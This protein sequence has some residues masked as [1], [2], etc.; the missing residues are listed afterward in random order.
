MRPSGARFAV[1]ENANEP[2]ALRLWSAV[3]SRNNR[4]LGALLRFSAWLGE[5]SDD[6]QVAMLVGAYLAVQLAMIIVARLG[7]PGLQPILLWSWVGFCIFSW[8]APTLVENLLARD[9]IGAQRD[10]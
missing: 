7:V 5:R 6:R 4:A 2:G 3:K 8:Y 1:A 9:V 10:S